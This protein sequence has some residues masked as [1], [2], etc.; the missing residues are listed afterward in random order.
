M[1]QKLK[2]FDELNAGIVVFPFKKYFKLVNSL[3]DARKCIVLG[4]DYAKR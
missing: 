4:Y 2:T 1:N 3:H